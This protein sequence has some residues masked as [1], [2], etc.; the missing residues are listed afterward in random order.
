MLPEEIGS[1]EENPPTL[2]DFMRRDLRWC[3]GNLQYLR[4]LGMPG[5]QPISRFQLAWAILM[6]IGIPAW[7]LLI[8]LLPVSRRC[9]VAPGRLSGALAIGI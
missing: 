9:R 3:Q 2:L 8:A 4:L 1:W 7:T 5:L 6:F